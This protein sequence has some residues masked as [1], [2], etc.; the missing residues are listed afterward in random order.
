MFQSALRA[1]M[2]AIKASN[3]LPSA[4][5][6]FDYYSSFG[7]FRELMGMEGRRLLQM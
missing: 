6:D 7:A 2:A 5:D 4:G 1:T 3:Q